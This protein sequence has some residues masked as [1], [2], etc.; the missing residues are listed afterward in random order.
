LWGDRRLEKR[1]AA[2][3]RRK[4]DAAGDEAP[5]GHKIERDCSSEAG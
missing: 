3:E 4:A 2:G 5:V 1:G